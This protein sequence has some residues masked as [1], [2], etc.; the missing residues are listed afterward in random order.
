MTRQAPERAG[1]AIVVAPARERQPAGYSGSFR[2]L[3]CL[4]TQIGDLDQPPYPNAEIALS[5]AAISAPTGLP[6][7]GL[8]PQYL[9]PSDS[10]RDAQGT[11]GHRRPELPRL[12]LE[13]AWLEAARRSI[14]QPLSVS[15]A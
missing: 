6:M 1:V 13:R 7:A 10:G 15:I 8:P 11:G 2:E 12:R 5:K 9:L 14:V 3:Y 4:V